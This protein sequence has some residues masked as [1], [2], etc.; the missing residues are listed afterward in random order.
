MPDLNQWLLDNLAAVVAV[1]G[2]AVIGLGAAVV[3][4]GSRLARARSA[5]RALVH[6][7]SGH[8]L[9]DVLDRH[10]AR[11]E[12][13]D[14]RLAEL[15]DRYRLLEAKSGDG[16][17]HVGLVRFNP[18]SDTGSDQSFAI[19]LLND[20]RSGIVITSLHARDG[21]RVFA[22]SIEDGRA[23]H[24]LSEEEGEALRIASAGIGQGGSD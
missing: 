20:R 21:T 7:A 18:F 23:T 11:V 16:L 9:E 2:A 4:L 5:S 3:V 15:D 17:Q 24:A 6:E 19:A 13:V 8:S 12:A 14:G 10:L 1:L 22:K